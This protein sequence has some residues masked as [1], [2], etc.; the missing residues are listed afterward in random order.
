VS[1]I[2]SY[3]FSDQGFGRLIMLELPVFLPIKSL[4]NFERRGVPTFSSRLGS[5]ACDAR[6]QPR[7][8]ADAA[9]SLTHAHSEPSSLL[10]ARR[11]VG[12]SG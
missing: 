11:G 12:S 2:Q 6:S 7:R 9:T 8:I 3:G 10:T 4:L 1:N 5:L